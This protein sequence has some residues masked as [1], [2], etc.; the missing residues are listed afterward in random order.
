MPFSSLLDLA[1]GQTKAF[2]RRS[3]IGR[4]PEAVLHVKGINIEFAA[5][6]VVDVSK[7]NLKEM[8]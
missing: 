8:K 7:G 3:R 4:G 1:R 5:S 2:N 6:E